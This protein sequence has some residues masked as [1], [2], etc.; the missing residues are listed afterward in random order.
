MVHLT[1]KIYFFLQILLLLFVKG[2]FGNEVQDKSNSQELYSSS[3]ELIRHHIHVYYDSIR[4]FPNYQDRIKAAD[5]LFSITKKIGGAAHVHS[6]IFRANEYTPANPK[7]FNEAYLIAKELGDIDLI[8]SVEYL[9]SG[10]FLD[11]KQYDSAVFH[12]LKYKELT[13]ADIKG[14]GYQNILEFLGNI[15]Y[16]AQLY[17]QATQIYWDILQVYQQEKSWNYYRP[18][19]MMNNLGQIAMK[20]GELKEAQEWFQE[21]LQLSIK[22]LNQFYRDNTIAYTRIKLAELFMIT[23]DIKEAENQLNIVE[24]IPDDLINSDVKEEL[25]FQK[26]QLNLKKL[27]LQQ[28]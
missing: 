7:L 1:R 3:E 9:R 13:P 20:K 27:N 8:C 18:Y 5:S 16:H 26:A 14:D 4:K 2:V 28:P 22:Y 24:N 12:I 15:Y 11:R 17:D 6:L 10:Y 25:I 21:S 19:V 23:G